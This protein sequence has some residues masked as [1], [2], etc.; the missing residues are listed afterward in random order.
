[1]GPAGAAHARRR[2][3]RAAGPA[4][5]RGRPVTDAG[6]RA[7]VE[8]LW[9]AAVPGTPGRDLTA[10]LTA[11]RDGG[12]DGLLV[13]AFDAVDVPDPLLALDAL[14]GVGFLV[15][16]EVRR[17]EV[18]DRADVVLPVAAAVEKTGTFLDW[19]GRARPFEQVLRTTSLPDLRVLHTLADELDVPLGLPDVAA[20][21]AEIGRLGATT[22]RPAAPTVPAAA[23]PSLQAGE[24]V[25]STWH[26]LLDDG[27]MQDGEPFL[28]GTAKKPRLHLSPATAAEVGVVPGELVTV[29]TDRG[30][31]TLPL[32]LADLPDRVVWVPTRTPDA[33]VRRDLA[34]TSGAVVRLSKGTP[35]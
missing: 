26:W 4:R 6:A 24:A 17:S 8:A 32:V 19:E 12:L 29:T 5:R 27:A 18:T 14:D 9:G 15:S 20:A 35:A 30:S 21:R 33:A 10:I 23:A 16:L 31:L 28:A 34:A 1:A 3:R 25:L 13:G 7:E 11:A 22:D 2:A